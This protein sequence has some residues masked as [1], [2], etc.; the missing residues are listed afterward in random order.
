MANPERPVL[1]CIEAKF[2]KSILNTRVKPLDEIYKIY[3]LLRPFE[4]YVKN[5]EKRFWQTIIR[6][7]NRTPEKK[8]ADRNNAAR[9]VVMTEV[10]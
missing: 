9:S 10:L 6:A 3:T 2:C 7:K 1:G 4:S 5:H 8:P